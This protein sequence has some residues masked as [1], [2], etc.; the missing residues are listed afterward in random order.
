MHWLST[1]ALLDLFALAEAY[2][3]QTVAEARSALVWDEFFLKGRGGDAAVDGAPLA[4]AE[5]MVLKGITKA[6]SD[7]TYR[8]TY[9]TVVMQV[10]WAV[11]VCARAE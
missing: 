3:Q 2:R 4:D 6:S 7:E 1:P 11:S 10:C 9:R 5:R 8:E